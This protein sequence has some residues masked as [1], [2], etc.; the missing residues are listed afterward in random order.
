MEVDPLVEKLL[1][2]K[3]E[4]AIE[5][6]VGYLSVFFHYYAEHGATTIGDYLPDILFYGSIIGIV[7]LSL[8]V[9]EMLLKMAS[10]ALPRVIGK[11]KLENQLFFQYDY[12]R[13]ENIKAFRKYVTGSFY[14]AVLTLIIGIGYDITIA[15]LLCLLLLGLLAHYLYQVLL[16]GKY[17]RYIYVSQQ[18]KVFQTWDRAD[19]VKQYGPSAFTRELNKTMPEIKKNHA[20]GYL[21]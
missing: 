2:G 5:L 17:L 7:L 3:H 14:L 16:T 11:L 4:S 8:P 19:E 1:S 12:I 10:Y 13:N 9:Y 18:A 15:I 21:T 20:E 6:S